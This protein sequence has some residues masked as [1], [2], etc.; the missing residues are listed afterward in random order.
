MAEPVTVPISI[1]DVTMEFVRPNLRLAAT[2][3]D[4]VEELFDR[5]SHWDIT[6]DDLESVNEGKPS[7]QGVK[8]K[9]PKRKTTFFFSVSQARLTWDDA[10]WET[11]GETIEILTIGLEALVRHGNVEV[12]KYKTAV[13]LHLQPKKTPFIE[14]LKPFASPALAAIQSTPLTAFATV[15]RWDD[16]RITIDGSAQIANAVFLR[17]E[18]DFPGASAIPDLAAGILADERSL[19]SILGVEEVTP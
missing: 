17:F 12:L 11:A 15:L 5:F 16:R 6:V 1:F 2:R 9:I 18:R 3:A 7:E 4:I 19:Y 13:S 14:L 8:F 10:N